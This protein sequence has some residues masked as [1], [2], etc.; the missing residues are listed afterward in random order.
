M[1]VRPLQ[2]SA[3]QARKAVPTYSGTG[4]PAHERADGPKAPKEPRPIRS[5]LV[6]KA[7]SLQTPAPKSCWPGR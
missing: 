5:R 6:I 4:V 1:K 3:G 2:Y 7:R